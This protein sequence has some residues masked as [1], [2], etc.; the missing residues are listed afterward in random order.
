MFL[1]LDNNK[2]QKEQL[3][4]LIYVQV[5][6]LKFKI[7]DYRLKFKLLNQVLV[8]KKQDFEHIQDHLKL[9]RKWRLGSNS[10]KVKTPKIR[11]LYRGK[12]FEDSHNLKVTSTSETADWFCP[13][14][15]M[16]QVIPI[17]AIFFRM[18]T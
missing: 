4:M 13:L 7:L 1:S 6:V 12:A 16:K 18:T 2:I 10:E 14:Q 9:M 3:N 11:R 5:L 8:L 17:E 15:K